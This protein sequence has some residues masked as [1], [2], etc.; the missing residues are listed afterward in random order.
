[1]LNNL[2][3][4]AEPESIPEPRILKKRAPTP[5]PSVSDA[6]DNEVSGNEKTEKSNSEESSDSSDEEEDEEKDDSSNSDSDSDSDSSSDDE[7][8]NDKGGSGAGGTSN[9]SSPSDSPP[10]PPKQ[11]EKTKEKSKEKKKTKS[12]KKKKRHSF[13]PNM[14]R[15]QH[16]SRTMLTKSTRIDTWYKMLEMD[17]KIYQIDIH[18]RKTEKKAAK[19]E[20]E[21]LMNI[22]LH[23]LDPHYLPRVTMISPVEK[24]IEKLFEIRRTERNVSRSSVKSEF[25]KL[26]LVR[27]EQLDDFFNRLD[28]LLLDYKMQTKTDIPESDVY[29]RLVEATENIYPNV[30]TILKARGANQPSIPDLKILLLQEESEK[31]R[32]PEEANLAYHRNPNPLPP[33]PPNA[34]HV[35]RPPPHNCYNCSSQYHY[36]WECPDWDKGPR[37]FKCGEWGHRSKDCPNEYRDYRSEFEMPD[38][39]L[40]L[41]RAGMISAGQMVGLKKKRDA[42]PDYPNYNQSSNRRAQ[43]HDETSR[44]HDDRSRHRNR[45]YDSNN[46]RSRFSPDRSDHRHEDHRDNRRSPNRNPDDVKITHQRAPATEVTPPE[47]ALQALSLNKPEPMETSASDLYMDF[48]LIEFPKLPVNEMSPT[49]IAEVHNKIHQ[50]E[51]WLMCLK[52]SLDLRVQMLN[53]EEEATREIVPLFPSNNPIPIPLMDALGPVILNHPPVPPPTSHTSGSSTKTT[54]EKRQPTK[55]ELKDDEPF[56]QTS[57]KKFPEPKPDAGKTPLKKFADNTFNPK[58]EA[59]IPTKTDSQP[60]TGP[61]FRKSTRPRRITPP[62]PNRSFPI[63]PNGFKPMP[64]TSGTFIRPPTPTDESKKSTSRRPHRLLRHLPRVPQ[65]RTLS[66]QQRLTLTRWE[67]Q[68]IRRARLHHPSYTRT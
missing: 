33:P 51:H 9:H 13:N 17:A 7:S 22:V 16:E 3:R 24:V 46:R 29:D 50:L 56:V 60:K 42:M 53:V 61:E 35:P 2:K 40:G 20:E 21:Q 28:E 23:R 68:L 41:Y 62:F 44:Y 49:A 39:L 45:D 34:A 30:K 4:K 12:K 58:A 57:T 8:D 59:K 64:R 15:S 25:N 37:C 36:V 19:I 32:K 55:A 52:K 6:S 1:M 26:T 43:Y 54:P 63:H 67:T 27:G 47:Q 14:L 10:E 18:N 31:Y 65:R 66:H 11:K 48:L 38:D 5:K